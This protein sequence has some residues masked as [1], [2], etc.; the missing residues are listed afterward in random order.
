MHVL[1]DQLQEE[2]PGDVG[3]VDQLAVQRHRQEGGEIAAGARVE[4]RPPLQ[5]VDELHGQG[6]GFF[7]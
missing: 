6:G 4:V 7:F 5:R 3:V 2:R 1:V